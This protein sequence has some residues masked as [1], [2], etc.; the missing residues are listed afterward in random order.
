MSSSP[1]SSG[2]VIATTSQGEEEADEN[3]NYKQRALDVVKIGAV[4]VVVGVAVPL[5]VVGAVKAVGFTTSGIVARS[6][7][8]KAMSVAAT[9]SYSVLPVATAQSIGAAGFGFAGKAVT[10]SYTHLTLPTKRIV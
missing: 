7:A 2:A 1:H 8:A 4:A 3:N 6:V 5:V 9:N 10:V